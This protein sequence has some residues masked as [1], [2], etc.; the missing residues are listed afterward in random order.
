VLPHQLKN[1]PVD[2]YV[3]DV[4]G[5]GCQ[6]GSGD[7]LTFSHVRTLAEMVQERPN[8]LFVLWSS[9][10]TAWYKEIVSEEFP[11]LANAPNVLHRYEDKFGPENDQFE[12]KLKAWFD[13]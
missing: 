7:S 11:E 10:T 1:K 2:L 9:F 4:G 13:T 12:K 3:F 8:T 6:M 5:L